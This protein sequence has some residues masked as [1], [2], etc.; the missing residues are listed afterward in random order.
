MSSTKR[1][2]IFGGSILFTTFIFSLMLMTLPNL[3]IKMIF[4]ISFYLV[5]P[6]MFFIIR[7]IYI[8]KYLKQNQIFFSIKPKIPTMNIRL[9]LYILLIF[10][11]YKV[12]N[13]FLNISM[14]ITIITFV[15]ISEI[16]LYL[17][18]NYTLVYFLNNAIVVYG[19]DFRID[20]PVNDNIQSTSGIYAFNDFVSYKLKNNVLILYLDNAR[21]TLSMI[22]PED[23][24]PHI[25]S[26]V[27]S[28]GIENVDL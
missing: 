2:L 11:E 14:Y 5:S 6:V 25:I 15:I 19:L 9:I 27:Q 17:S 18:V 13:S 4:Y 24:I 23:K 3:S 16:Y 7:R 28:K 20:L 8:S 1:S 10:M 12:Y 21:G 26:F 22:L